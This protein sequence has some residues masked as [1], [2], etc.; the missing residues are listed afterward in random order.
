LECK[1]VFVTGAYR[2]REYRVEE[3]EK[4]WERVTRNPVL[5]LVGWGL[6]IERGRR[7]FCGDDEE[8][9]GR[10]WFFDG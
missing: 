1:D 7:E 6:G 3:A 5:M 9:C 2:R 10:K 4:A 8:M